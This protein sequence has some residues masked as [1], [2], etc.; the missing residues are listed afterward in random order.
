MQQHHAVVVEERTAFSEESVVEADAD[1]LEHADRD[2]TIEFLR[3][4]AI[5]LQ[6][7]VDPAG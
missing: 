2:D 6:T 7:E 4:V 1:V 3:P 5:V